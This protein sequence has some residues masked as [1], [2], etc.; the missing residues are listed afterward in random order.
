MIALN[1]DAAIVRKACQNRHC[2]IWVE[3]IGAIHLGHTR[4]AFTKRF[5]LHIRINS[6]YLTNRNRFGGLGVLIQQ[7]AAHPL[8][9]LSSGI[10]A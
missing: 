5:D 8:C 9:P 10:I 1:H 6:E 2:C 3:F 4:R 7:F